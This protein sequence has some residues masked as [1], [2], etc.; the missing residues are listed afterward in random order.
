[1][2]SWVKQP[3]W[4]THRRRP[5]KAGLITSNGRPCSSESKFWKA[6]FQHSTVSELPEWSLD[7]WRTTCHPRSGARVLTRP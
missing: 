1:M 5:R 7:E 2:P 4:L 6:A 3:A